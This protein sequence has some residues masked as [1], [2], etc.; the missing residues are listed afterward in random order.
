MKKDSLQSSIL[1]RIRGFVPGECFSRSDFSD[2]GSRLAVSQSLSRLER[3]GILTSPLRGYYQVPRKSLVVGEILPVDYS[4]LAAAIARNNGWSI[5]PCGDILLN[6]MGLSTQVPAIWRYVST[7]PYRCYEANGMGLEFRHTAN[8]QIFNM[9]RDTAMLIQ[10]I[11]ALGKNPLS[12]IEKGRLAKW[13]TFRDCTRMLEEMKHT[14]S[15]I[16][17]TIQKLAKEA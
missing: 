4:K 17:E 3:R 1:E 16:L 13:M 7:G 2:L 6:E 11:K 10:T 9:S 8:K 5:L 12:E 14:T 15:W